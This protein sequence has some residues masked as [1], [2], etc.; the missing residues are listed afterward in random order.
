METAYDMSINFGDF[1]LM[2]CF[3]VF[4]LFT[5]IFGGANS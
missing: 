2:N 3:D 4:I 5:N 1:F